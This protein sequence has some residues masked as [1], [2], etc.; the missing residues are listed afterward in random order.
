MQL[1]RL[2]IL[3]FRNLRDFEITFT[4]SATDA[5]G[6]EREFR[7]HA[8]IGQNGSGKSNMI[9]AIIT[10]FRDLDLNHKTEFAYELDYT[11]RGHHVQVNTMGEKGKV[12][13]TEHDA[14]K[15]KDF[16]LS[17]LQRHAR[18]F[19]PSH[20]FAYYSGRSERIEGLFQRSSPLATIR[21]RDRCLLPA[22]QNRNG[23][24]LDR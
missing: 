21:S 18:K 7:S 11:C 4:G 22:T 5:D 9:E 17:Y 1:R 6:T 3:D 15:S 12:T 16:A 2:K 20:V 10:I 24:W 14:D 8:V 13:I 23:Q 19:L